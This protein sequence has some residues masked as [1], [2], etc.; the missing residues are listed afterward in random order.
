MNNEK[1]KLV[2]LGVLAVVVVGIGA[3]SFMGGSKPAPAATESTTASTEPEPEATAEGDP[4]QT[5]EALP[6]DPAQ[7]LDGDGQPDSPHPTQFAGLQNVNDLAP[8][9]PFEPPAGAVVKKATPAPQPAPAPRVA[10]SQPHGGI[11]KGNR[12]WGPPIDGGSEL[13]P[14]VSIAPTYRVKGILL[15]KRPVAVFEDSTGNQRLVPLGGSL[16]GDTQVTDISKGRVTIRHKG[17]ETTLTIEE[18]ARNG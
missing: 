11:D 1:K 15:G 18:E 5:S 7:D 14:P 3:F 4:S 10:V 17:K 12:P 9:D 13:A 16:D 2:I 8:R 6:G